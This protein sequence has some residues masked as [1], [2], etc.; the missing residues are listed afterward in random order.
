MSVFVECAPDLNETSSHDDAWEVAAQIGC[1]VYNPNEPRVHFGKFSSHR[2]CA[3][4][5]DRGW[6]RFHGPW[7]TTQERRHLQHAALLRDDQLAF[8]VYIRTIEDKT[9]G[10]YWHQP[11]DG[12]G[13]NSVSKTGYRGIT[14]PMAEGSALVAALSIW[15]HLAPV[16][17]H[18]MECEAADPVYRPIRPLH[19]TLQEV[20]KSLNTL[21]G[22]TD[23][24]VIHGINEAQSWYNEGKFDPSGDSFYTWDRLVEILHSEAP[25][26]VKD[27]GSRKIFEKIGLLRQLGP[28]Y[29]PQMEP[30]S[31]QQTVDCLMSSPYIRD[32]GFC[33]Y[34][35]PPSSNPLILHVELHRHKYDRNARKM[36]KL[37]HFIELNET[38]KF[39]GTSAAHSSQY[40]LFSIIVHKGGLKAGRHYAII[41]PRGPKSIW[42]S[43]GIRNERDVVNMTNKQAVQDHEGSDETL[44]GERAVAHIVTYVRSDCL[45]DTSFTTRVQP[46]GISSSNEVSIA[47]SSNNNIASVANA[48]SDS[49]DNEMP[50]MATILIFASSLA[51]GHKGLQLFDL[52]ASLDQP[53]ESGNWHCFRMERT[54]TIADIKDYLVSELKVP[55]A[56]YSRLF[57]LGTKM[58]MMGPSPH[59]V[60][61]C[62]E[63]RT[64]E[65]YAT[66]VGCRFLIHRMDQGKLYFICKKKGTF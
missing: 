59:F 9:G 32:P 49:D 29:Q 27:P 12:Q 55:G 45:S 52:Q 61:K 44:H 4:N 38:I 7:N 36:R 24:V 62:L 60:S 56:K 10:L 57:V 2:F 34:I 18:I 33:D 41:R 40:T 16:Y 66:E 64:I 11:F 5:P 26:K 15:F 21:D 53:K 39:K 6:T 48:S 8:T 25:T 35:K 22:S 47:Q 28:I 1:V 46:A 50:A 19:N 54:K 63:D 51:L 23:P 31:A 58:D 14:W 30:S 43:Y 20:F 3:Q 42:I 17:K 37:T 65:T 13:W